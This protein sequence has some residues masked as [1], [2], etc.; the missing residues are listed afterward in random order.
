MPQQTRPRL[1][2]CVTCKNADLPEP[3]DDEMPHGQ[4]LHDAVAALLAASDDPAVTLEPVICL[5][6]CERGCTITMSA[7]GKWA[8]MMGGLTPDHAADLI[9]YGASF[10]SSRNGT[11]FRSKRP[12][13]LNHSIVAR[14]PALLDEKEGPRQ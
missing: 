10:G 13:S 8:Y 11:V 1:H 5:A 12:Q 14:F 6:N 3:A 2:V 7:P 9:A 4:R